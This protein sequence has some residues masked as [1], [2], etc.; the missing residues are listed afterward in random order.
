MNTKKIKKY[1]K[2]ITEN[3]IIPAAVLVFS[4]NPLLAGVFFAGTNIYKALVDINKDKVKE[5]QIFLEENIEVFTKTVVTSK[6]FKE[7]L[8]ITFEQYLKERSEEKRKI[9]TDIFLD[10]SKLDE[11][12]RVSFELERYYNALY[13]ISLDTLLFLIDEIEIEYK[14]NI[15][16]IDGTKTS[17]DKAREHYYECASLGII[18]IMFVATW[19]GGSADYHFSKFGIDFVN[20]VKNINK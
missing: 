9:I 4:G 7:G 2:I 6:G 10:Y 1:G 17:N 12:S 16:I 13:I 20:R 14:K 15:K 3:A 8:F 19:G 5:F 18:E 11:K